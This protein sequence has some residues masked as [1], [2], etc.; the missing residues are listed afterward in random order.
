[1]MGSRT[2]RGK[3]PWLF[4]ILA[5]EG[6]GG[7]VI[8]PITSPAPAEALYRAPEPLL[9]KLAL[10]AVCLWIEEGKRSK[11]CGMQIQNGCCIEH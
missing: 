8:V 1:M 2:A 11:W 5:A 6:Y 3:L 7:G 4:A 10:G 9:A